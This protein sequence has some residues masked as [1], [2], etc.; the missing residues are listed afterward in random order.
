[1]FRDCQEIEL[2]RFVVRQLLHLRGL[3]ATPLSSLTES[4][5]A[6]LV[7]ARQPWQKMLF[8]RP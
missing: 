4:R 6:S 7:A 1:M 8:R 5:V 3:A 2:G